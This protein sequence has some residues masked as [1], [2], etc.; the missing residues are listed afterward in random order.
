MDIEFDIDAS[1]F[2]GSLQLAIDKLDKELSK[3]ITN[4]ARKIQIMWADAAESRT[5]LPGQNHPVNDALYASFVR[6]P[7][8]LKI[9]SREASITPTNQ[10]HIARSEKGYPAFDMKPRLLSRKSAKT[11]KDGSL[12][13]RVPISQKR[14][15]QTKKP[16]GPITFRIVSKKSPAGSWIHPGVR[17]N[18]LSAAV[19]QQ[20][21]SNIVQEVNRTVDEIL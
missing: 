6:D 7:A 18:N 5:T 9:G 15:P 16:I 13:V 17:G 4:G 11:G 1:S 3:V 8:A 2:L 14:N 21:E 10:E 19:T 20:G 12:Y